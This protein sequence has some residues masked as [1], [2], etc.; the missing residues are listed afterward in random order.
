MILA[1]LFL[2]GALCTN[3]L[4]TAAS[5]SEDS[6]LLWLGL[7]PAYNVAQG[8][9]LAF[10]LRTGSPRERLRPKQWRL[11]L[12][13]TDSRSFLGSYPSYA[14]KTRFQPYTP[15]GFPSAHLQPTGIQC[16]QAEFKLPSSLRLVQ[17]HAQFILQRHRW[18]L[19]DQVIG[20]SPTTSL[21]I[22]L[23]PSNKQ[24]FQTAIVSDPEVRA[25]RALCER[26]Q[27][28]WRQLNDR[29]V[30]QSSMGLVEDGLYM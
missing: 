4:A 15:P 22:R 24:R 3:F 29:P 16:F 18:L 14:L 28:C 6:L 2:F 19:A 11:K 10:C 23:H 9:T 1:A 30:V 17:T 25:L 20:R 26:L 5:S 8:A 7:L 12:Q 13:L 21:S 27:E